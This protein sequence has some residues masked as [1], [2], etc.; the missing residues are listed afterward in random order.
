MLLKIK[1]DYKKWLGPLFLAACLGLIVSCANIARPG[2]GPRDMDPPIFIKSDPMPQQVNFK[3]N[4]LEL[5]FDEIVAITNPMEKVVVSPAQ[6]EPP[7]IKANGRRITIDL[8]D[9]LRENTTYSIDFTDA[10]ADNNESNKL[11]NFGFSFSTGPVIDTMQVYGYLLN[12]EDLEPI[13]GMLVGLHR[14][15]DDSAFV[16]A[17]LDRLS[18]SDTYGRFSI[19]NIAPGTYRVYGL[20]DVSRNYYYDAPSEDIAFDTTRITPRMEMRMHA[21]TLWADSITIDTIKM[22]NI[23]HYFPDDIVLRSFNENYKQQYLDKNE[24]KSDRNFALYFNTEADTLPTITPLNL[25]ADDW[26]YVEKSRNN[27]TITYWIKD[28]AIYKLD[29]LQLAL[30]YLRTDSLKALSSYNDT[31][32]L[33]YKR[34]KAPAEN[35]KR[36]KVIPDS[37]RIPITPML[38]VIYGVNPAFNVYDRIIVT[39]SEPLMALDTTGIKLFIKQDSTTFNPVE[40]TFRQ[41]SLNPRRYILDTKWRPSATYRFKVD[42]AVMTGLYGLHNDDISKDFTVKSLDTYSRFT[43]VVQGV[44]GPAFV[45]MLTS[46]DA[47]VAQAKVKNGKAYFPYLDPGKYYMR[48]VVDRNDNGKFDTGNLLKKQQPEMVYYYPG[49]VELRSNWVTSQDWDVTAVPLYQQK[50]LEIIKN[51][52]KEKKYLPD[53]EDQ[54][55]QD[56]NTGGNGLSSFGSA[57]GGARNFGGR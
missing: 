32:Q 22:V 46:G 37:L 4:K 42:S 54:M 24:R 7:V 1:T 31:L 15:L 13:T 38:E 14:S 2:G 53:E 57:I 49:A 23:P 21:D 3:K 35:K 55:Y 29:T 51:K 36:K 12:A 16:K 27:D 11:E 20:K 9:S 28:S 18:L 50:P 17:P 26:Y 48:L 8:N 44:Q 19:R 25:K 41:D 40:F 39:P 34:P 43:V 56:N 52:P 30:N 47:P 45:Q 5:Y 33:V 10:I 6:K